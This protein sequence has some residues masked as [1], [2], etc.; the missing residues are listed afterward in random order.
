MTAVLERPAGAGPV[1]R[2][3][4]EGPEPRKFRPDIEGMR[5]FAVLA[6]VFYH[7]D[8]GVRGGF[9]GVDVF[10]V[11]SGFLITRQLVES[12][13]KQGIRALPT[14]Y[15]RRIRRLLPAG[16]TVVI[17]T[18]VAARIW[19]PALQVRS[20]TIDGIFTTFYGL[21]YRLAIEG[22]QYL[23]QTDSVS[24]L[25]HFWSLGVEE[26]FYVVWPI[27]I[28]LVAWIGR[29]YRNILLFVVLAAG[30]ALSYH[31]SI[32][33][34]GQSSSW[35]YFSLHT[36]AWELALG[37]L[38]AIGCRPLARLPRRLAGLGAWIGLGT[39]VASAFMFSDSTKYPGSLAAVPVVGAA[40][41]I[42]CGCGPRLKV[43]RVLG[44]PMLQC[45]GR[46]SYSWYLWH[47]PMLIMAPLIVGHPLTWPARLFVI[48][49]S[50]VVAIMSYFMIENPF[51][52]LGKRN[53]QGF[54]TG[55]L[56]SGAVVACGA[57]ILANLPSVVGSGAA[58]KTNQITASGG[59]P[60][61][62]QLQADITAG[63]ATK[64]APRNLT[65]IPSSAAED[66]PPSSK[67]G[68]HAD[69]LVVKQGAC[70]FGDPNGTHTAV[71][72]GD[73]HMEQWL[74]AFDAAAKQSHWKIVNWTK[75]SCPPAEMTVFAPSL[76]RTYTECDTWRQQ[77]IARIAALHPDLVFMSQS[78][79]VASSSM[80]PG[81]Y[82]SDTVQTLNLLKSATH[83]PVTFIDDIPIPNADTPTCVA[84]HLADV[85]K[86]T[87]ALKAAY[88]YPARHEAIGAGVKSAGFPMVDPQQWLCNTSRCPAVVG[89]L[90][91]YRNS[92][93]MT[94]TYSAWLMPMVRPL[95]TLAK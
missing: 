38:V 48:W 36:R 53:W 50:F 89:N 5:A 12:V 29:R 59:S 8:L 67:D 72:F 6:V 9:I 16:A 64:A 4:V 31:Y 22:T 63:I 84:D 23:H 33:V 66:T 27:L 92:T 46:I 68:C 41:L 47:W 90:L 95:L 87:F 57:L 81:T 14:F 34:T 76:N 32:V 56:I 83:A 45:I 85:T 54:G 74:P 80:S 88:T 37:G 11:I 2:R 69:F 86:C 13:G 30:A 35:A 21:N 24:P 62:I 55:F 25:Q 58:V 17:A 28:V 26:Q 3:R 20:I 15:T 7:A 71:L 42:A 73:S 51:R 94:A 70:V 75:A 19:A 1:G 77:T 82:T 44:E 40:L 60:A 61:L 49:L 18:I 10:F 39:V 78:E 79:N 93:H 65:P 52:A 91:V 43:E